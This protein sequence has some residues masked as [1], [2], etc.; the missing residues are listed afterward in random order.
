MGLSLKLSRIVI[1][2]FA[3]LIF[4]AQ[5][6]DSTTENYTRNC[7]P[8]NETAGCSTVS[9][10]DTVVTTC[11]CSS[12]YCNADRSAADPNYNN[13]DTATATVAPS[14]NSTVS[15]WQTYINQTDFRYDQI[16]S[17]CQSCYIVETTNSKLSVYSLL[18]SK[19]I[20]ANS[21]LIF[22]FQVVLNFCLNFSLTSRIF[23]LLDLM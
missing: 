5:H 3:M 20:R 23:L 7:R 17:G 10:M 8:S 2:L 22:V 14:V 15:C 19:L 1:V 16:V 4:I 9:V 6:N 18:I 12:D 21:F 11:V 13:I